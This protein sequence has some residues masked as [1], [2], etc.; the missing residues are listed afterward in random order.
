MKI[1]FLK[2]VGGVGRAGEVKEIADG[3]AMNFLIPRGFAE[4][5]TPEKVLSHE[6]RLASKFL[7]KQE[8]EKR[9]AGAIQSI[10]GAHIEIKARA[11][12]KGGL[13]KSIGPKDIVAKITDEQII[14]IPEEAV[15]LQSPIKTI[16]EHPVTVSAGGA[17]AKITVVVQAA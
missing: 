16:G 4:Q 13:F 9:L 3:Y 14:S 11:T 17:K 12:E 10:E 1:I 15:H 7:T 2:D 5:A 8:E 6:K